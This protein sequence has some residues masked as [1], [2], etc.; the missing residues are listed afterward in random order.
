MEIIKASLAHIDLVA[1]LFNEYRVFYQQEDDL[2]AAKAFLTARLQNNESVIFLAS[3]DGKAA[4]F[5]QLYPIFSSISMGKSWLLND[6]FVNE[7][8]RKKGLGKALLEAAQGLANTTKAKWTMLQTAT[9]NYNAQSLYEATGY[10]KDESFF[11]YYR[12]L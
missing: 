4:G 11:T 5:T 1:P 7:N 12:Y 8:F 2:P 6:L 9:D 10:R 3:V